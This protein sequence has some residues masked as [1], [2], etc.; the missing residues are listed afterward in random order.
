MGSANETRRYIVRLYHNVVSHWLRSYPACTKL[1][2]NVKY[3][4][5]GLN[6]DPCRQKCCYVYRYVKIFLVAKIT[7]TFYSQNS[8]CRILCGKQQLPVLIYVYGRHA[9]AGRVTVL[10]I[11]GVQSMNQSI[12]ISLSEWHLMCLRHSINFDTPHG[13]IQKCVWL[14]NTPLTHWGRE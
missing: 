2:I 5:I 10:K 14:G 12:N 3:V 4:V 1:A 11:E 7:V 8:M 6:S 13:E 9:I